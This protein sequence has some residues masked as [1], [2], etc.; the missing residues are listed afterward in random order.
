MRVRLGFVVVVVGTLAAS[1]TALIPSNACET[2]QD[3]V[4]GAVC[5][6]GRCARGGGSSGTSS[7]VGGGSSSNGGSSSTLVASSVGASSLEGRSSSLG[8]ASSSSGGASSS[9][10]GASSLTGSGSSSLG[11][12]S[13]LAVGSSSSSGGSVSAED[14]DPPGDG[15]RIQPP[16]LDAGRDDD[17]D[18]GDAGNR[19]NRDGSVLSFPG[20]RKDAGEIYE[21]A[22]DAG[23]SPDATYDNGRADSGTA[24]AA[25]RS[26][27]GGLLDDGR[28]PGT[29]PGDGGNNAQQADAGLDDGRP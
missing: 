23:P 28:P 7:S 21:G 24:D 29:L 20:D 2:D 13:S 1:C 19:G 10:G 17:S 6:D 18:L 27:D 14:L 25:A 12:G 11:N 16:V 9:S 4:G 5:V 15:G 8:G 26:V 22:V 3:C